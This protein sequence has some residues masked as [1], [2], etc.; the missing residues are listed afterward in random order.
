MLINYDEL[1]NE[2]FVQN[3]K[4][5]CFYCREELSEK[6]IATAN[7]LGIEVIVDG[8]HTV[9]YTN[10]TLPTILLV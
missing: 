8:T 10:L 9:S 2:K 3:D 4:N 1:Q 7:Q 6:L 5:R